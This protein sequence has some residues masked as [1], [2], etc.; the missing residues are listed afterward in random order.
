MVALNRKFDHPLPERTKK[1]Y[2]KNK[3]LKNILERRFSDIGL[4]NGDSTNLLYMSCKKKPGN[5]NASVR[6]LTK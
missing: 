5:S 2:E 4:K 3:W 6:Y 1:K